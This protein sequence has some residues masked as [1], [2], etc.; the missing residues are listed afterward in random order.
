MAALGRCCSHSNQCKKPAALSYLKPSSHHRYTDDS[1]PIRMASTLVAD[2]SRSF[3]VLIIGAG[4]AGLACAAKLQKGASTAR[5]AVLEAR[6]RIGGRIAVTLKGSNR[7]DTGA[8][9]IHGIGEEG[10]WNPILE[11]VAPSR[12][13]EL[14]SA[15]NFRMRE[16]ILRPDG[17]ARS[18]GHV[19]A[20]GQASSGDLVIPPEISA[21]ISPLLFQLM[22]S[23]HEQ[24]AA[25]SHEEARDTTVLQ[26][27]LQ[28][29]AFREA[30][31]KIPEQY[32]ASVAGV[33]QVL[34]GMEAAPLSKASAETLEGS[35]GMSLLEYVTDGFDG[36]QVFL[37]DG[38]TSVIDKLAKD[39]V[40]N[41]HVRLNT[42]VL[43][44]HWDQDP[45]KVETNGD[46]YTARNVVCAL[47]LGVLK[48]HVQPNTSSKQ[49][50]F[51]PE[52]PQDKVEAISSLGYGTL[53]KIFMVYDTPWWTREPYRSI[54]ARGYTQWEADSENTETQEPDAFRGFTTELPGLL[55]DSDTT[56]PGPSGLFIINL[57]ALTGF[58][59]LSAFVSCANARRIEALSDDDGAAIV[60]R[61]LADWLG[62]VEPPR[63]DAVHVTRWANDPFARGSYSHMITGRSERRHR[64][65]FE[66]PLVSASGASLRFAGEHTSLENFATAHGALLSGQREADALLAAAGAATDTE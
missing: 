33:P 6:D 8:N 5:F 1:V 17:S 58:P 23:L 64:A 24:A 47:P 45:I 3:D 35:P 38:Y 40:E 21:E 36:D 49:P 66:T 57:H 20:D 2:Q 28:D 9:W 53:D 16:P 46:T 11:Y 13:R 42:E 44:I 19:L 61:A 29:P 15:V 52:L 62:G 63:P 51:S 12:Y 37:R 22:G 30:F 65:D 26:G 7:L 10:N 4:I 43:R 18:S 55:V 14:K 59:V 50:F 56:Q 34:E 32:R 41:G 25:M 48:H 27:V 54:L 31:E 60:H 39:V